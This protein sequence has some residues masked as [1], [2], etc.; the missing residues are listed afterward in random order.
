MLH[1]TTAQLSE[2][3]L[4]Y[5]R[6]IVRQTSRRL[7]GQASKMCAQ[8]NVSLRSLTT[9]ASAACHHHHHHHRIVTRIRMP[10]ELSSNLVSLAPARRFVS[11]SGIAAFA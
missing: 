10:V 1:E 5:L 3:I 6:Q 7:V 9:A 2:R 11:A 8:K 4:L